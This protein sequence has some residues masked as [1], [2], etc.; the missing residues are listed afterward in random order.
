MVEQKVLCLSND[1]LTL[2]C[3]FIISSG[4]EKTVIEE[5]NFVSLACDECVV[6]SDN[7]SLKEGIN[8]L[9]LEKKLFDVNLRVEEKTLP[10]HKTV[11]GSRSPVLKAMFEHDTQEKSSN[12]VDIPDIDFSTLLRMLTF[13]YSDNIDTLNSDHAIKLYSAADKY[14]IESSRKKCS[15]YLA[16]NV[17]SKNVYGILVLANMHQNKECCGRAPFQTLFSVEFEAF[18]GSHVDLARETL[19]NWIQRI[20]IEMASEI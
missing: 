7:G 15:E 3:S 18:I 2:Q 14:Q 1:I 4:A 5:C 11:L 6:Q 17:T 8:T 12:I 10:A 9:F 13:L 19:R 16:A 20:K